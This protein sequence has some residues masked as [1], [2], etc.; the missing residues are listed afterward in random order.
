[1][2]TGHAS[3]EPTADELHLM[4][5]T[6]ER[7]HA[8]GA[9]PRVADLQVELDRAKDGLD[10]VAVGK[11]LDPGLGSG[12]DAQGEVTLTLHG[13]AL[14][15]GSSEELV[16]TLAVVR[17][18][19]QRY[20]D[21]GVG[22]KIKS[23]VLGETFGL[24]DLRLRRLHLLVQHVPGLYGGGGEPGGA[25]YR[26]TDLAIRQFSNV[27]TVEEMLSR[28]PRMRRPGGPI[29]PVDLSSVR[30]RSGRSVK[31]SSKRGSASVPAPGSS[32]GR[33]SA[34]GMETVGHGKRRLRQVQARN[35]RS[36]DEVV[37]DLGDLTVL[38]G[39]NGSGKTNLVDCLSFV[40][41]S[42][43]STLA[44]AFQLRGGI[45]AVRRRSA[46]HPTNVGIRLDLS[47]SDTQVASYAFEIAARPQWDFVVKRETCRVATDG[48]V[49]AV[50]DLSE[51]E[52][53]EAPS[54]IRPRIAP[55]RLALPVLSATEE[56][57]GVYDFI[58]GMRFY[59]L[60]PDRIR[61]L[62][63]PDTGL[64]L[65]RDGSNAASVRREV[66]TRSI[67]DYERICSLL[68]KVVP[69][70]TSVDYERVGS[71]E[72]LQFRQQIGTKYPWT[73]PALNMSDGTLRV[74]GLLLAVYQQ[75]PPPFVAV[76]EPES[77][78]H[79]GALDVLVDVFLDGRRRSQVLL[80]TH[81]PDLLDS[82]KIEDG[83]VRVVTSDAGRTRIS[84]LSQASR[85]AVRQGLYSTG[86]LLRANSLDPD[87][88]ASGQLS[89]ELDLFGHPAG[90]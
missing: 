64:S 15:D 48:I 72:T 73:F 52:F 60:V 38:V 25:W 44:R 7:F 77:T 51:G 59:A 14:C 19:Y 61:E 83:Q 28:I 37:V 27:T 24:S 18:A 80:T 16:D 39:P 45:D 41:D 66:K 32:S 74:L 2:P 62:Q 55:D 67:D 31:S 82:D 3:E 47:L 71:K 79:P 34:Q 35:F 76:E 65:K 29:N 58:A 69:G 33:D 86:E 10:V 13:I 49:S 68:G 43:T 20:L 9:W 84:P 78:V 11:G 5:V 22:A 46:G 56:F 26:Q 81:S 6:F 40:T 50:Y 36:L 23:H 90:D 17:Y 12:H 63:D 21:E 53:T 57:R 88:P 1:M 42:V 70:T 30:A 54:G 85:E 87:L 75:P 8:N 89:A 4:Q